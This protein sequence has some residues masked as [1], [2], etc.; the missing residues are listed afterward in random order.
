[1]RW[2]SKIFVNK[3][4]PFGL[5]SAPIIFPAVADTLQWIIEQ[6]RVK[7]IFHYADDFITVGRPGSEECWDNLAIIRD[8]CKITGI[9]VE[10]DKLEG[11][12]PFL[13][14]LGIELDILQLEIRLPTDKLERLQQQTREWR[15]K[16]AGLKRD[17][18]SLIGTLSHTCKAVR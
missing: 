17:L 13:P 14:F 11:P 8:T 4:L 3:C 6:K 12:A 2:N 10:E 15:G 18:L 1:M 5:R 7:H 9:P 16:R